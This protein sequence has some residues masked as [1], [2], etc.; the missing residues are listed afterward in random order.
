M[1]LSCIAS[2]AVRPGV[3]IKAKKTRRKG[4]TAWKQAKYLGSV[5]GMSTVAY[6][7]DT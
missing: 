4:V 2:Q 3:I 1:H 7:D 5:G 6:Y